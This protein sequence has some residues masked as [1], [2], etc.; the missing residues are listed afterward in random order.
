MRRDEQ[1]PATSKRPQR[2]TAS[3]LNGTQLGSR[4]K[5]IPC[6]PR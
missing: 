4:V 6:G 2:D 1:K 5:C 3:C